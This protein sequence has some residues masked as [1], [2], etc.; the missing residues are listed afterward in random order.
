MSVRVV[1]NDWYVYIKL[2]L[3]G[4]MNENQNQIKTWISIIIHKPTKKIF[5]LNLTEK[6][7]SI[8]KI[9]IKWFMWNDWLF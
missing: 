8:F 7:F 3:S 9:E 5:C 4:E 2:K 6:V 1:N